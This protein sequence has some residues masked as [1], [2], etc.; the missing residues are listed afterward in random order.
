[1]GPGRSVRN[2]ETEQVKEKASS[3]FTAKIVRKITLIIKAV[4]HS[5]LDRFS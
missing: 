4:L 1:M 2:L 3:S 5:A